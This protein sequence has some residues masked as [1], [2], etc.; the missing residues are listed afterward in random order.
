MAKKLSLSRPAGTV[1]I[2]ASVILTL[3]S[4]A[5]AAGFMVLLGYALSQGFSGKSLS[6]MLGGLIFV[7]VMLGG[8][9]ATRISIEQHSIYKEQQ[10]LQSRLLLD[11]FRQGSGVLASRNAG[12]LIDMMTSG[13]EK[14]QRYRQA[15]L[16]SMIGAMVSP[17]L[18][19]SVMALL[20]DPWCALVLLGFVPLVPAIVFGFSKLTRKVSSSSRGRRN[21]LA[22]SYLDALSGL[23]TLTL[24]GAADSKGQQLAQIGEENRLSTMR[25]LAANQLILLVIDLGFNLLLLTTG[26]A[27]TLWKVIN[28]AWGSD[29]TVIAPVVSMVGLTLLLLEPMNKIGSFFYVGMAGMAN[30]RL[31]RAFLSGKAPT[32]GQGGDD[33]SDKTPVTPHQSDSFLSLQDLTFAYSEGDPVLQNLDL[34]IKP[35]EWVAICGP[36]G[37]GKST[38]IEVLKGNLLPSQGTY[39]LQGRALDADS[40]AWFADQSALVQQRTW[41][42]T[43]TIRSNLMMVAPRASEDRL[44]ECLEK[45]GLAAEVRAFA[46]GLDTPVGE[47]G[48][49][50]SGGQ[51]QRL[52][53]ARALLSQ[54]ELLLLDE[55]TSQ[56]DLES[57]AAITQALAEVAKEKTIVLLTHRASALEFADR[58]LY[59][60][61][62]ALK[63][64]M[65]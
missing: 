31:V 52:S 48:Y 62:G 27:L 26:F 37:A 41:I 12:S 50:L 36:S 61:D 30:Q 64:V 13:T 49:A 20:V 9:E 25:L 32:Q 4:V 59:L 44:W 11:F 17:L 28:G 19:L 16:G 8:C 56:I 42:F 43:G 34:E 57:E 35:G 22:A 2:I 55:P 21:Q 23:E 40:S 3:I 54:R 45:V 65:R 6:G 39:Y 33:S 58:V 1:A 63:E 5:L 24:L 51:A 14:I 10:A 47:D 46:Q 15:F 53:L 60:Q 29:I 7:A 18:V 38:L